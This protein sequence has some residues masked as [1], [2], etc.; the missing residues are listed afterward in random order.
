MYILPINCNLNVEK[1]YLGHVYKTCMHTLQKNIYPFINALVND[2]Q[3]GK[4][5]KFTFKFKN[6][7]ITVHLEEKFTN[8]NRVSSLFTG[9]AS[10]S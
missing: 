9:I 10:I 8:F 7:Q 5:I 1:R 3:N 2:I 4:P 6:L